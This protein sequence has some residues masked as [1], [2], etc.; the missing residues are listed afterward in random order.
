MSGICGLVDFA[1]APADG[2]ALRAM[3]EAAA[4][5]GPDGIH[6][7]RDGA[8]AMAHLMLD[9][10][11]ESFHRMSAGAQ[12]PIASADGDLLLTADVRLDNRTELLKLLDGI[13][14]DGTHLDETQLDETQL[15]ETQ[16]VEVIEH[17]RRSLSDVELILAAY[18]RWGI[19]CA[20]HLLGDFA[21][22]LWDRSERRLLCA[23]DALGMKA[24]NYARV[25]DLFLFATE[26]QQI[27]E[28]PRVSRRLDEGSVGEFLLDAIRT[29]DRTYFRGVR[30]LMPAHRL[31]VTPE[32][33]RPE[34]YWDIDPEKSLRY[35][36]DEEYAEHCLDLLKQAV[37]ARL[38]SRDAAVGVSMSGGLDSTSVTAIAH[39]LLASGKPDVVA[40][41]YVFDALEDCD[42]SSNIR[43]MI[44][45]L[46]VDVEI[47]SAEKHWIF[48]DAEA[49]EPYPETPLINW[50]GVYRQ[51]FERLRARGA[52][53][54]LG[55]LGGDNLY[56]GSPYSYLDRAR[57]GELGVLAEAA[58]FSWSLRGKPLWLAARQYI[59][60]PVMRRLRGSRSRREADR[61]PSWITPALRRSAHQAENT[62][63]GLRFGE[64]ARQRLY[65][66]IFLLARDGRAAD[67]MDRCAS[68]WGFEMRH[69]HLDRRL[70]E[71][72]L[73]IPSRQHY[74]PGWYKPLLRRAM[75]GRL[76]DAVRH[77][78]GKSNLV[79]FLHWSLREKEGARIEELL[80][81]P[82][83]AE[84][85][86]IEADR[87]LAAFRKYRRDGELECDVAKLWFA[88]DFEM[89]LR[90]FHE[91]VEIRL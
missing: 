11:P 64:S 4:Y 71:F 2:E 46:G 76:P 12:Q 85:G 6:H 33:V 19:A 55:G 44:D 52:R 18:R 27:L 89:W 49:H 1:G 70:V 43:A 37:G 63:E 40:V 9:R 5:R 62:P 23:R 57:R 83:S 78:T 35:R 48:G 26:A 81:A 74:H 13:P 7:R 68:R 69:P 91:R 36:R 80:S 60:R 28:H 90:R 77:Q 58:R 75:V 41:S 53:V 15:D 51:V 39:E 16:P 54:M 21:F 61:I 30:R 47:F 86:F 73:S 20:E 3:A 72:V 32:A 65:D 10:T 84:L 14:L 87:L 59:G 31:V 82:L 29:S 42:E 17:G 22:A 50:E 66:N 45:E 38:R 24:F 79:N 25:G 56:M 67:W 88:I 8:V 34:R